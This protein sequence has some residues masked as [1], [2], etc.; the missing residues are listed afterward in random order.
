MLNMV[1][2][3]VDELD[4]LILAEYQRDAGVSYNA[5]AEKLD[6]PTSTVFNRIKKMSETGIIKK[7]STHHRPSYP[8]LH[9]H[10]MDQDGGRPQG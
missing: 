7:N 4:G 5:L 3:E 2:N 6:L 8:R 10:S 1:Q 9:N